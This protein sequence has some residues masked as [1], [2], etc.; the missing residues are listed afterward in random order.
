MQRSIKSHASPGLDT[1]QTGQLKRRVMLGKRP[2]HDK[3]DDRVTGGVSSKRKTMLGKREEQHDNGDGQPERQALLG[4]SADIG[5]KRRVMLGK[6]PGLK[7]DG[8]AWGNVRFGNRNEMHSPWQKV[9]LGKRLD[10][11]GEGKRRILLGKRPNSGVVDASKRRILLG[12]R[13]GDDDAYETKR[14][15]MLGKRP[16]GGVS[17]ETK[18]RIM[19]GKRPGD[20]VVSYTKRRIL[21]GKRPLYGLK[22]RVVLGQQANSNTKIPAWQR[23]L[24]GKRPSPSGLVSNVEKGRVRLGRSQND[25][26]WQ[27]ALTKRPFGGGSYKW[28]LPSA[29]NVRDE[30]RK[31]S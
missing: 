11:V 21:L 5:V 24:F 6:R 15:I 23:T 7:S 16:G 3:H 22:R 30:R 12:K 26:T 19:L 2:I 9:R 20:G 31:R 29:P 1:E 13:Q 28:D 14:T 18:R 27:H 8:V 25:S 17:S 10:S 4:E